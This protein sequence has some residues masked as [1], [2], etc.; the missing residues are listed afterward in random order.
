MRVKR[1][2]YVTN[3]ETKESAV[4]LEALL[5]A[6]G[7]Q[8]PAGTDELSALLAATTPHINLLRARVSVGQQ[9]SAEDVST[10]RILV[11]G[12]DALEA[13]IATVTEADQQHATEL[14]ELLARVDA[15]AEPEAPAEELDELAGDPETPEDPEPEAPADPEPEVLKGEVI[16][17]PAPPARR[18]PVSFANLGNDDVPANPVGPAW[19]M[20][21]GAPGFREGPVG[22]AQL[23][24][25]VDGITKGTRSARTFNAEGR[26]QHMAQVMAELPRDLPLISDSHGLVAEIERVT[27]SMPVRRGSDERVPVTAESLVAAGGWCSPSEILYDFCDV[28]NATDLVS[29]PEITINRGGIRWPSEPDMTEVF[30]NFEF[31]FTEPELI[32]TPPVVKECV[33]IPCPDDFKE[34]RLAV[35]GYCVSA[36]ILQTQGWP[37][38]I[39]WF[40]QQLTAEHLRAISRRTILDM[41]NDSTLRTFN[42]A[43]TIGASGAVLNSLDIMATNIR[44]NRG[45]PRNAVIEG[46]APSWLLAVIR[47]DWAYRGSDVANHNVTDAQILSWLATRNIALQ[48]VGDWQSRGTGQ[49]GRLDTVRWPGHV[50]V[51][52]YPAGTWFRAMQNVIEIGIMYPKEQLVLNRYT[53][54][55]TEDAIA[56][57]RRCHPS[58]VVRIPLAV[59]GAI[60]A[61]EA[62]TY[63]DTAINPGN[64]FGSTYGAPVP[65]GQVG[66]A[67]VTSTLTETGSPTGGTVKLTLTPGGETGTI[68]FNATAVQVREAIATLGELNESDVKVTG[69]PLNTTPIVVK[70]PV[71]YAL[72]VTSPAL[73]GGSSPAVTKS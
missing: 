37:E 72:T 1:P 54:M 66:V 29:V 6:L 7:E 48:F 28:P 65:G 34:M 15:P 47:A 71:G 61:R 41:V 69:G 43:D 8:L 63:S 46:V 25:A 58:T 68:P 40:M 11:D 39:E 33:E 67:Q 73:T 35:V 4:D 12:R 32:A 21:Q 22:F 50:D 23:A 13:E 17:A 5:A 10:L 19:R 31:F 52:L 64:T 62:I 24:R 53:R 16:P 44:L 45:L 51:L 9:L 57:G 70:T 26:G 56:V 20:R 3:H 55:F 18:D 59:D 38:L 42:V 30:E 2:K 27:N 14:A 49:P 36:G 60:G